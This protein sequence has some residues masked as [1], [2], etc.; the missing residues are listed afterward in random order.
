[1]AIT[2]FQ[3]PPTYAMPVIEDKRTKQSVFNPIWLKWFLDLSQNLGTTGA[4]SGSGSVTSVSLSLPSQFSVSG[5]PVTTTGVLTATWATQTANRFFAGPATGAAATPTFRALVAADTPDL[6]PYTTPEDANTWTGFADPASIVQSYDSTARTITITAPPGELVYYWQG[7]KRTL[8]DGT[9]WTSSAHTATNGGWF[10]LSTDG[11]NITWSSVPWEFY[12]FMLAFVYYGVADKFSLRETHGLMDW[13]AHQE[14]HETVGTYLASGGDLSGYTLSSTVAAN[15]RPMVSSTV[16]KDE[17]LLSTNA[18]LTSSLYTKTFLAGAGTNNFTVETADIVPLL[19]NNPYWNQ[20]TGGAWVQTLMVNNTYMCVWLIAVPSAADTT[21]QKYR[22][23]WMQG[24]ENGT[25]LAMQAKTPTDLN[26]GSFTNLF[27][28]F[29]FIGK[30]ILRF[31]AANWTIVQVDKLTGTR[32]N[33]GVTSSGYLSSVTTDTTLSGAGTGVSPLSV[34]KSPPVTIAADYTVLSTDQWII[35]NKAS[36]CVLTLP[37][38][39]TW[40]G[41]AITVQNYQ[42]FTVTSASS[43][44]VPEGGGAAGTAILLGA[45]GSWATLVSDGT[46]WV[47]MQA[48]GNSLLL[49]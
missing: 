11:T 32:V 48:A 46:N 12:D 31:T 26:K 1:M 19:G 23:I 41:R 35:N 16:V 39:A 18:T 29:V 27:T 38:A 28:E 22:Y 20:F 9:T 34:V 15:R 43:N 33:Q 47:I 30:L 21:S 5:S 36:A 25:L 2:K 45:T 17:D 3:P 13:N 40:P 49:E 24:Q 7:H 10:L 4:G 8:G 14:F 6:V 37:S 42:A 44:V